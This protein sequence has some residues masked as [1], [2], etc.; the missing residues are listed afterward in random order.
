MPTVGGRVQA[1][2]PGGVG[3]VSPRPLLPPETSRLWIGAP[4]GRLQ[5]QRH[6]PAAGSLGDKGLPLTCPRVEA[7]QLSS[8]RSFLRVPAGTFHV[9]GPSF[10]APRSL[11]PCLGQPGLP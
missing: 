3:T 9:L 1:S 4:R 7:P 8:A 10:P 2:S 5:G 11:P 6:S